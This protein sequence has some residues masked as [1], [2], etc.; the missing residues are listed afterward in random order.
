MSGF[1]LGYSL[2]MLMSDDEKEGYRKAQKEVKALLETNPSCEELR[3]QLK[4][5]VEK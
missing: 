5:W 2:G 3:K 4:A 1:L